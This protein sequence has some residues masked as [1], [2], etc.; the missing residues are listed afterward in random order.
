MDFTFRW[1]LND[2]VEVAAYVGRRNRWVSGRVTATTENEA[3]EALFERFNHGMQPDNF[4][5][6]SV[7]D[8]VEL[9]T[10]DEDM[11]N[12]TTTWVCCNSGWQV[13]PESEMV[14]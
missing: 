8:F 13:V 3:L 12:M 10:L 11:H 2:S 5:S 4:R 14:R 7:N 1:T 9:T 6:M